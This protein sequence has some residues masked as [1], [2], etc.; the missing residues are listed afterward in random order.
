MISLKD[1]VGSPPIISECTEHVS[2]NEKLLHQLL[3]A[4]PPLSADLLRH[5]VLQL[6]CSMS[7]RRSIELGDLELVGKSYED[8]YLRAPLPGERS[9]MRG[10]NCMCNF[11]AKVRYG[12]ASDL[13]FVGVEFLRPS[14]SQIWLRTGTLPSTIGRCVLCNRYLVTFLYTMARC[15]PRVSIAP[16]GTDV[17]ADTNAP[18]TVV[19]KPSVRAR[20]RH[21]TCHTSAIAVDVGD[22]CDDSSGWY[23]A[24]LPEYVNAVNVA[25]GYHQSKTLFY[26]EE[27]MNATLMRD[28]SMG[29]M[30]FRPF[31]RFCSSDYTYT[32]DHDG[33]CRIVQCGMSCW[34]H[35]N[36]SAH[37]DLVQPGA[38]PSNVSRT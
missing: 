26:E 35:L 21:K 14:D 4:H 17:S 12:A 29:N 2:D 20:R 36:D 33:R 16:R 15:N 27:L 31:V 7:E 19:Q 22:G 18:T 37:S 32:R 24:L 9:C 6:F 3:S 5:D 25:D 34:Q 13:A 38:P 1:H 23:T 10:S 28:T 8:Q 30:V 11:I